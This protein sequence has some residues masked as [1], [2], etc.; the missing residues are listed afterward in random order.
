MV[1]PNKIKSVSSFND[2][3]ST[4]DIFLTGNNVEE[5]TRVPAADL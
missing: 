2:E 5:D 3:I 1:S 4:S